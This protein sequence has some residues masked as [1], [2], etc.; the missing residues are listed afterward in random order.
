MKRFFAVLMSLFFLLAGCG[1]LPGEGKQKVCVTLFPLYDFTLKLAGDK[2]EIVYIPPSGDHHSTELS[3]GDM[4]KICDSDLLIYNG[5]GLEEWTEHLLAEGQVRAVSASDGI[6]LIYTDEGHEGDLRFADPH[7]W[8]DP[9]LAKK[10]MENITEALTEVVPMHADFFRQNFD[11]YAE[12]FDKLDEEYAVALSGIS[13][14]AIVVTHKAFSYLCRRYGL[15]QLAALD[16]HNS[17]EVGAGD[18]ARLIDEIRQ[19]GIKVIFYDEQEGNELARTLASETGAEIKP[20]S[21]LAALM[22]SPG[23]DYFSLMR[24]NLQSLAYALK[25]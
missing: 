13:R 23:Y 3:A 21:T 11:R 17:G 10:Q 24:A 18:F 19:R 15:E 25:D 6:E 8:L 12:E 2:V 5:A 1:V 16:E 9:L 14:N 20:L 4:R 22:P 7:V